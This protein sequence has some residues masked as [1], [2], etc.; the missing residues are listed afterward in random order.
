MKV[1]PVS[2]AAASAKLVLPVPG[3][4]Y[5]KIAD[6]RRRQPTRSDGGRSDGSRQ[7]SRSKSFALVAPTM[8][9]SFLAGTRVFVGDSG[10][11]A[12]ASAVVVGGSEFGLTAFLSA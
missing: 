4:P 7:Q 5:S 3:G 10:S 6:G 12:A 11:D 2:P 8:S 9:A 1:R